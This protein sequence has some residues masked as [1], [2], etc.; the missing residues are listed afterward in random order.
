MKKLNKF[1]LLA[2]VLLLMA[3]LACGSSVSPNEG[4]VA[5]PALSEEEAQDK[6]QEDDSDQDPPEVVVS[7]Q[8][9]D[10]VGVWYREGE[11]FGPDV[12]GFRSDG[13]YWNILGAYVTPPARDT[14][15]R[16]EWLLV[17]N[18]FIHI[19]D[20][21]GYFTEDNVF[22]YILSEDTL[23]L[24]DREGDESTYDRVSKD[25]RTNV[26]K[27]MEGKW[28]CK[29]DAEFGEDGIATIEC[30]NYN[31]CEVINAKP[32][33]PSGYENHLMYSPV[34]ADISNIQLNDDYVDLFDASAVE[35]THYTPKGVFA[36]NSNLYRLRSN[37]TLELSYIEGYW[38]EGTTSNW[39]DT[40]FNSCEREYA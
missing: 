5:S 32:D 36:V 26:Q 7:G 13:L 9:A 29:F 21:D 38:G 11:Y 35:I 14:I 37:S 22:K 39:M 2:V 27:I 33:F 25:T 8:G 12:F 1:V 40:L 16:Y 30:D 19:T 20:A 31:S 15:D 3:S 17:D 18:E 23:V 4:A 34:W 24:I 10:L 28:S 6:P